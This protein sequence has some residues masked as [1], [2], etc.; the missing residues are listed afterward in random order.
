MAD[1][2]ISEL[3]SVTSLV[4]EDLIPVVDNPNGTPQ[5]KSIT[6]KDFFGSVSAN[7]VMSASALTTFNANVTFSNANTVLSSN[8]N[9]GGLL[10]ITGTSDSARFVV[11][12]PITPASNNTTTEFT[13]GQQ[14]SIFWDSDYLYVATSNTVIKRVALSVF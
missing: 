8:T 2:K 3:T 14:G 12:N 4:A 7:L 6:V 9:V 1:R 13:G 5:T 10:K 11:E